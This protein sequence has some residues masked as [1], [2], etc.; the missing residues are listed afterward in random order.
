MDSSFKDSTGREWRVN[1][2]MGTALEVLE[3]LGVDLLNPT[4]RD[5]GKLS[6]V[7]VLT[8]DPSML[9]QVVFFCVKEPYSDK[10]TFLDHLDGAAF[11]RASDAFWRAYENFFAAAGRADFAR[12]IESKASEAKE[13]ATVAA[14]IVGELRRALSLT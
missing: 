7:D 6:S 12:V 14:A 11:K 4:A 13:R 3:E 2:T 9:A 5:E 8:S 1:I 10:K